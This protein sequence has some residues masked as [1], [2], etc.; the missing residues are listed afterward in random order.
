MKMASLRNSRIRAL[1]AGL[2]ICCAAAAANAA[3]RAWQKGTWRDVQIKRPKVVFGVAPNSP[4]TGAPRTSPPATQEIRTYVIET[5]TNRYE[6]RE[7]A[8]VDTPRM[9]VLVGEPVEFA[10]EKKTVWVKDADG[11]EHR[12]VLMKDSKK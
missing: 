7:N 8:T 10:I 4:N 9:D 11:H 2:L 3:E 6:L 5:E 1:A 12:L